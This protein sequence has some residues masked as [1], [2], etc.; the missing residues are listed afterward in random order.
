MCK[1]NNEMQEG[2]AKVKGMHLKRNR[3]LWSAIFGKD[4]QKLKKQCK[5]K[6]VG[7]ISEPQLAIN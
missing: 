1:R 2:N 7:M 6:E 5:E 3:P 4:G